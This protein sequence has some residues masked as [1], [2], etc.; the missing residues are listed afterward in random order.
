MSCQKQGLYNHTHFIANAARVHTKPA[1]RHK[2]CQFDSV[3]VGFSRG[4]VCL[5]FIM[6]RQETGANKR[7]RGSSYKFGDQSA[8][9]VTRTVHRHSVHKRRLYVLIQRAAVLSVGGELTDDC[10][11]LKSGGAWE[12]ER[13]PM[14]VQMYACTRRALRYNSSSRCKLS[15]V[16][17]VADE[18]LG[19]WTL[20]TTH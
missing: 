14:L 15:T 4:V 13:I 10:F 1:E 7:N 3:W 8:W 17:P 16:K 6:H 9:A 20:C 18:H 2:C 19:A 5:H 12:R 11:L